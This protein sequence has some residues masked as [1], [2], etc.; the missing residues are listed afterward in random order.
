MTYDVDEFYFCEARKP[1]FTF[2]SFCLGIVSYIHCDRV[3][4]RFLAGL[5][6]QNHKTFDGKRRVTHLCEATAASSWP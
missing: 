2:F 1:G 4:M 3:K 6:E 5:I